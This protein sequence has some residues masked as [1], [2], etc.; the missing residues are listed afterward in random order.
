MTKTFAS[1][2]HSHGYCERC[3]FRAPLNLLK[4]ESVR[5]RAINNRVCPSCYDPDHPQNFLGDVR[6]DDPQALRRPA[7]D[8]GLA[9]SRLI[10]T[11][12]P[13]IG[14]PYEGG[15]YA[16]D[17]AQGGAVFRIIVAPKAS[18]E[19]LST[20]RWGP[21]SAAPVETITLNNGA[22][23]SDAINTTSY[24]AA[25]FCR[26]LM[27]AGRSDWYLPARDEL[28]LCYRNLK[29]T[30]TENTS[31][32]RPSSPYTYPEN[33]DVAGDF[34]GINRSSIPNGLAYS[35]GNPSQTGVALFQ[36]GGSEAFAAAFYH[37]S[38]ERSS[39]T[40]WLQSFNNGSQASATKTFFAR[41]RAV[42]RV[43]A[44]TV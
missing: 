37:S 6:V 28:E 44:T 33:P 32:G 17:I 9:A 5:G 4:T 23:A 11:P 26:G 3:G 40:V 25:F 30:A 1:G 38:T 42:R 35:A 34:V 12:P 2:K 27:I 39:T 19:S 15:Y 14:D 41:V 24:G 18:G 16:G 20:L 7:T 43:L 10:P 8:T 29:P 22:A 31:G 21:L 13:R 36:D